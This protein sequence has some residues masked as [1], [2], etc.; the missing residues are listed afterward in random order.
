MP[1]DRFPEDRRLEPA[2]RALAG[3]IVPDAVALDA[4]GWQSLE[5]VIAR[6]LRDRPAALR[7]QLGLFIRVLNILPLLR[8]GRTFERLD[9]TRRVRFLR[10]V[11]RA[12]LLLARRGFWGLRTLVYMGYYGRPETHA[13]LG[14]RA[15]PRGWLEHSAATP[16]ARAQLA[17]ECTDA[18]A[19]GVDA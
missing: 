3:T 11:E 12:P 7:R 10:A 2:F 1:V 17:A 14:Y 8:W 16:E 4:A 9:A 15:T 18:T 5:A 6:A 13:A 19:G